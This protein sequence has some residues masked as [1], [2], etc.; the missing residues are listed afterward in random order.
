M[1][2][3]CKLIFW[4]LNG[5]SLH[6]PL[7]VWNWEKYNFI[8]KSSIFFKYCIASLYSQTNQAEMAR[9]TQPME[10]LLFT[11]PAQRKPIPKPNVTRRSSPSVLVGDA[12]KLSRERRQRGRGSSVLRG[13]PLHPAPANWI[14]RCRLCSTRSASINS[15]SRPRRGA[16]ALPW[17][18]DA[19]AGSVLHR[20]GRDPGFGEPL[21]SRP[22]PHCSSIRRLFRCLHPREPCFVPIRPH[23][24]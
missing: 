20:Q 19:R 11:S 10:E 3:S 5:T 8:K 2:W 7:F 15:C 24:V 17:E 6:D 23:R 18:D 21:A 9:S 16:P 22:P 14:R 13:S 1:S 12:T 4:D